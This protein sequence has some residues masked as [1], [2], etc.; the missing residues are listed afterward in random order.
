MMSDEISVENRCLHPSFVSLWKCTGEIRT[1]RAISGFV[2]SLLS[3]IPD[4]MVSVWCPQMTALKMQ[5]LLPGRKNK[6][7]P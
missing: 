4:N 5:E 2:G 6:Q 7:N 1:E 3:I